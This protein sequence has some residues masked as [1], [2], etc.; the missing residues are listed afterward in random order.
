MNTTPIF[1]FES[2]DELAQWLVWLSLFLGGGVAMA[3]AFGY[4]GVRGAG[5]ALLAAA[6]LGL[7]MRSSITVTTDQVT[8]VRKWFFVP[9]WS[10]KADE[11]RDVYYGGDWGSDD[12]ATGVVVRLG[13][14]EVHLGTSRNM[15]QLHDALF[16]L[17]ARYREMNA[18]AKP[19]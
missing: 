13:D 17:S 18:A 3:I 14:E 19:Q 16:P 5:A 15:R 8:I 12:G 6:V 7:G 1:S 4:G 2:R 9:Y 11:I 10:Y